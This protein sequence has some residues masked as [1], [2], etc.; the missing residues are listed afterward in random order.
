MVA[1]RN[2]IEYIKGDWASLQQGLA[3]L[4]ERSRQYCIMVNE[5]I[6]R[7][8]A[9]HTQSDRDGEM[10]HLRTLLF[11]GVG[12][13]CDVDDCSRP[14]VP[15]ATCLTADVDQPM[16]WPVLLGT[17]NGIV[18]LLHQRRCQWLQQR[19]EMEQKPLD[20]KLLRKQLKDQ[21]SLATLEAQH[22]RL[23]SS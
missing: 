4:E 17:A 19:Q 13:D 8:V 3:A 12:S 6:E 10:S 23:L 21:K 15:P 1:D 14:H 18:S 11:V 20:A 2:E 5:A 9:A 22:A 7:V 16:S